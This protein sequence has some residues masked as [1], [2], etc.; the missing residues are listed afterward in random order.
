[1][2]T[3][4]DNLFERAPQIKWCWF[5]QT[6]KP[7]EHFYRNRS[8]QNGLSQDC[9]AYGAHRRSIKRARGLEAIHKEIA[10]QFQRMPQSKPCCYCLEIFDKSAFLSS[11]GKSI[12]SWCPEC[13]ATKNRA[14]RRRTVSAHL[15]S[16]KRCY[17][18]D[19]D[20]YRDRSLEQRQRR[21]L[22][23][24]THY[25][26][27]PPFC[28]CCKE[29]HIEFLS[30]DHVNGGGSAHRREVGSSSVYNWL[31][32]NGFPEG[33]RTLCMNCN[34]SFGHRGYCPHNA[35]PETIRLSGAPRTVAP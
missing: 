29:A 24:L 26:G 31:V 22:E 5:C 12:Y 8:R 10:L 3:R 20:K 2:A 33:F 9:K 6:N 16:K 34:L 27:S 25:S 17:R 15:A 14:Y 35:L 30:I 28:V 18:R 1:M 21:R 4:Q 11:T 13:R 7:F 19:A 23:V 32:K